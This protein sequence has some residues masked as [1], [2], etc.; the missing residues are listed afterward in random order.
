MLDVSVM[1]EPPSSIII[2]GGQSGNEKSFRERYPSETQSAIAGLIIIIFSTIV[3]IF[4]KDPSLPLFM[5]LGHF[6]GGLIILFSVLSWALKMIFSTKIG[7]MDTENNENQPNVIEESTAED[8]EDSSNV[9]NKIFKDEFWLGFVVTIEIVLFVVGALVILDI[10]STN[11]DSNPQIYW[12]IDVF[13]GILFLGIPAMIL[14][15]FV[16]GHKRFAQGSLALIAIVLSLLAV[17]GI[18]SVIIFLSGNPFN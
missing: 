1:Q 5:L 6:C 16:K 3:S 11:R 15:A 14:G 12:M 4:T 2:D 9:S 10:M 8:S 7:N 17:W 13:T 18:V